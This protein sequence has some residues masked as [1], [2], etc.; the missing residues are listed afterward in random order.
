[1]THKLAFAVT[2]QRSFDSAPLQGARFYAGGD[3]LS[4]VEKPNGLYVFT[5]VPA[6]PVRAELAG[7]Q[8][9]LISPRLGE[10][11]HV[12]LYEG[13]G[14]AAPY[15][16]R[17]ADFAVTPHERLHIVSLGDGARVTE[18]AD[19]KARLALRR[20]VP[21]GGWLMFTRENG[22]GEASFILEKRPPDIYYLSGHNGGFEGGSARRIYVGKADE[23]GICRI[24]LP[25]DF[26]D[27]APHP[28]D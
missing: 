3:P 10:C 1:M 14:F 16:Y 9:A 11:V 25:G 28:L 6:C 2:L 4:P 20:G 15:G 21:V 23:N 5:D 13:K 26:P 22:G 17:V 24:V 7:M 27:A 8:S 19:G 12:C 18:S